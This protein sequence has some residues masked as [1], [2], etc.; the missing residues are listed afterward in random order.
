MRRF[1]LRLALFGAHKGHKGRVAERRAQTRSAREGRYEHIDVLK[2]KVYALWA[3][4][5]Q[6]GKRDRQLEPS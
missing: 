3:T 6:N 1:M 5:A 4:F 2:R